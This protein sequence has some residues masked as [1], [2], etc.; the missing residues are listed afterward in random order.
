MHYRQVLE[1]I[2]EKRNSVEVY[3]RDNTEFSTQQETTFE[4]YRSAS[5]IEHHELPKLPPVLNTQSRNDNVDDDDDPYY[6]KRKSTDHDPY[7]LITPRRPRQS[8][9]QDENITMSMPELRN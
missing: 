1:P 5:V 6:N 3:Q 7:K 8:P 9:Q 2:R 4:G